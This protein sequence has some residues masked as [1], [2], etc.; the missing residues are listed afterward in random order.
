MQHGRTSGL[1]TS[2]T[3]HTA[4]PLVAI[5]I[6]IVLAVTSCGSAD[7]TSKDATPSSESRVGSAEN[8][9]P[10]ACDRPP[11]KAPKVTKVA[12]STS[13][14]DMVSFDGT[15]I[16]AHWFPLDAKTKAP[17]VLMGPGWS[18]AGDTNTTSTDLPTEM[19]VLS[20]PALRKAGYNVLTWDPRGFGASEGTVTIDS[21][22][23]EAR[24]VSKLIDWLATEKTVLQDTAG[25][26]R[27]GM[28]GASYGGGIQFVTAASDCRVD[29]ITPTIAWNS[30]QSS[31][32]KADTVKS[33]WASLL[34]SV[35]AGKTLDEHIISANEAGLT[36]GVLSQEDRDWFISRG[37]AN[38]LN[39]IQVP[40]LIVQGTVD[41]LFTLDEGVQ[42]F[43]ALA[44]TGVPVAMQWYCG[45]HGAC[46][47]KA[48][49]PNYTSNVVLAWL[50]R[51]VKQSKSGA[52]PPVFQTVDQNGK[53]HKFDSY[54]IATL[55]PL[56]ASGKGVLDLNEDGGSGP[57]SPDADAGIVGKLA[58]DITP[59]KAT[60]AVNIPVTNT[61]TKR[62][63]VGAPELK[64]TYQ[65][66]LDNPDG[67]TLPT[68]A[69]A[70]VIDNKTGK[71]LGNQV[72]PF[73][74][75]LD[76]KPHEATV[77]L[78]VV[79]HDLE[80]DA[81]LT[82]QLVANTVAYAKPQMGGSIDFTKVKVAFPI[83]KTPQG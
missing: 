1:L 11:A 17:T 16:R 33:G 9:Q 71:V 13:D 27:I 14:F 78:E 43:L 60:N 40:T 54:P 77:Y 32:Y 75:T 79:V 74:V 45:G 34:I 66:T 38:V 10:V 64:I 39:K 51:Y 25:D 72:T 31:L 70:Q 18:M 29:A 20:I 56:T 2:R 61:A 65:G 73:K 28:V 52:L 57:A 76:G 6:A 22:D 81:Q 7:K 59:A 53:V 69:F 36:T 35:A 15:K 26:P 12:G 49:P 4:M 41:G 23:Y 55:R 47:T 5:G 3:R 63:I 44:K 50:D 68:R 30:L 58:L 67:A 42:N 19:N 8:W 83:A 46:L 48:D 24:D 62:L 82:V 80:P 21:I 37:P